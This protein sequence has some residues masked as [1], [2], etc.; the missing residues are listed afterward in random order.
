MQDKS[1]IR[2]CYRARDVTK[3]KMFQTTTWQ[4]PA[5]FGHD[6]PC[7]QTGFYLLLRDLEI[8]R[9]I[10]KLKY[11]NTLTSWKQRENTKWPKKRLQCSR[12]H[13]EARWFIRYHLLALSVGPGPIASRNGHFTRYVP[14]LQRAFL[15][16]PNKGEIPPCGSPNIQIQ[17]LQT[18]LHTF[19]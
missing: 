14:W 16:I 5:T 12:R 11:V 17:I 18:D 4:I 15:E 3:M 1:L 2:D 9:N 6:R 7:Q 10:N 13:P 8:K 19:P